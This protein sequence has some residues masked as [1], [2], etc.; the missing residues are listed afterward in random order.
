MY[1]NMGEQ[2]RNKRGTF[3]NSEAWTPGPPRIAN[4]S[5]WALKCLLGLSSTK[6]PKNSN[7]WMMRQICHT[8]IMY[9]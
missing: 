5:V 7:N 9:I 4:C 6:W 1:S 2:T 3:A 8:I